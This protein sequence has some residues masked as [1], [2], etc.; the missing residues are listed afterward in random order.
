SALVQV[1]AVVG[2]LRP[3][4]L[5]P[6]S[7]ATGLTPGQWEALLAHELAPVRRHDYLVNLLQS[8]A[9]TMLFYHPAVWWVSRRMRGERENWWADLPVALCGDRLLSAR[10]LARLEELRQ[11]PAAALSVA[12]NGGSLM[13]RIRRL[14]G[15]PCPAEKCSP[16]WL[17]G[18]LTL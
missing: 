10:A 17:A 5:L 12:A 18:V 9:E 11:Q 16:H 15:L 8:I 7:A 4:G 1:P 13:A 14:L 2:W 3:V 6:V